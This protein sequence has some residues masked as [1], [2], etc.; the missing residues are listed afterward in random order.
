MISVE[1]KLLV[2]VLYRPE[3]EILNGIE[4]NDINFDNL[5]KL[6]S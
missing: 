6:A 4:I 2:N 3:S 1:E 5:I